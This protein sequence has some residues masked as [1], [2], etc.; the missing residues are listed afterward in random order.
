MKRLDDDDYN[1][2]RLDSDQAPRRRAAVPDMP[3]V[4]RVPVPRSRSGNRAE[5]D[6]GSD[7]HAC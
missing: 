6:A 4:K 7:N 2:D 1:G 3:N 5:T